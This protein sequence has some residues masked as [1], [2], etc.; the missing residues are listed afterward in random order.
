[1]QMGLDF[2]LVAEVEELVA[3]VRL[4]AVRDVAQPLLQAETGQGVVLN[5]GQV[6][7]VPGLQCVRQVLVCALVAAGHG[8]QLNLDLRV[9]RVPEV[10]G[11][12]DA[13]NPGPE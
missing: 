7:F 10:D 9:L 1:M 13:W 12:I 2:T 3:G 4:Q 5:L 6:G 8:I 11:V